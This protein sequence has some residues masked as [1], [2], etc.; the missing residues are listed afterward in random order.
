MCVLRRWESFNPFFSLLGLLSGSSNLGLKFNGYLS[1]S[2][3]GICF[4]DL[5]YTLVEFFILLYPYMLLYDASKLL[6]IP[7]ENIEEQYK[8][9]KQYRIPDLVFLLAFTLNRSQNNCY[10]GKAHDSFFPGFHFLSTTLLSIMTFCKFPVS[11]LCV[12]LIIHLVS[13]SF[14]T[15]RGYILSHI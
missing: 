4:L 9:P 11:T 10:R 8:M 2:N 6:G 15:L 3:Y 14:Q 1:Q 13:T 5:L 12:C 7:K